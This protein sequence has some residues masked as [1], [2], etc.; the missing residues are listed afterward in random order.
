MLRFIRYR[1]CWT[2]MLAMNRIAFQTLASA[3][4]LSVRTNLNLIA[5]TALVW[6][7][8]SF[9]PLQRLMVDGSPTMIMWRWCTKL[10]MAARSRGGAELLGG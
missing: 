7:G 5:L 2:A 3:V 10:T 6:Q 9:R 8:E 1:D 4:D